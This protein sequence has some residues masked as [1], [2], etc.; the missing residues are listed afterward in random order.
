MDDAT[1]INAGSEGKWDP[2]Q[3]LMDQAVSWSTAKRMTLNIDKTKVMIISIL[4]NP[5]IFH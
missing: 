4:N 5:W 2:M 1:L 3:E